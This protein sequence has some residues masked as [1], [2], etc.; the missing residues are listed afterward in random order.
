VA[1]LYLVKRT[2]DLAEVRRFREEELGGCLLSAAQAEEYLRRFDPEYDPQPTLPV[3]I[4]PRLRESQITLKQQVRGA[5]DLSRDELLELLIPS[6]EADLVFRGRNR[7]VFP[8]G[9]RRGGGASY[10]MATPGW[11]LFG[12]TPSLQELGIWLA[13]INPWSSQEAAW[14]ALTGEWPEVIPLELHY[15]RYRRRFTLTFAPWISEATYRRAYRGARDHLL[16]GDNRPLSKK[17]LAAVRFVLE[18]VDE[19]GTRPSWPE[20]T[21]LWNKEHPEWRFRNRGGLRKAYQHALADLAGL[22]MP[23]LSVPEIVEWRERGSD[24]KA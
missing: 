9:A 10:S 2:A 20:L 1:S 15:H 19:D 6:P 4:T 8:R 17:T 23:G 16:M 3:Q 12:R 11:V 18:S 14:F 24:G 5:K 13:T 21:R 22:K 7:E